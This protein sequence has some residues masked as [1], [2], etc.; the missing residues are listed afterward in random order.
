MKLWLDDVRPAPDGWTWVKTVDAAIEAF[1]TGEV[2]EADLDHDLGSCDVCSVCEYLRPTCACRCHLTGTYLV[3]WMAAENVW[4]RTQPRV[5]SAN[6]V[7]A[8]R[9]RS[10]IERYWVNR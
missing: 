5:H 8:E 3:N 4:P 9:M 2:T 7:G 6:P 10:M 1:R